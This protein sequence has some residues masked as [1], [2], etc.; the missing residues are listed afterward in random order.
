MRYLIIFTFLSSLLISCTETDKLDKK[1]EVKTTETSKTVSKEQPIDFSETGIT[2]VIDNLYIEYYPGKKKRIKFQGRQ[3][4]NKLRD[5][6]WLHFSYEGS[7][8]SMTTFDHGKKDGPT[9]VKYPN[10]NIHYIGQYKNDKAVDIWTTYTIDGVSS[11]KDFGP[12]GE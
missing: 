3:D 1:H 6:V 9:L 2:E 5:G 10:G 8:L 11:D 12:T 4:V 7:E